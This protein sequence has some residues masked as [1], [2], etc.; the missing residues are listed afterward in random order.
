MIQ[1]Q[2]LKLVF[3][4]IFLACGSLA[5]FSAEA[6]QCVVNKGDFELHVYWYRPA[7]IVYRM[8]TT[9]EKEYQQSIPYSSKVFAGVLQEMRNVNPPVQIAVLKN[10]SQNCTAT[11]D[12]LVALFSVMHCA[13]TLIQN[14]IRAC[15]DRRMPVVIHGTPMEEGFGVRPINCTQEP[16]FLMSCLKSPDTSRYKPQFINPAPANWPLLVTAPPATNYLE[17]KG[18]IGLIEVVP[19]APIK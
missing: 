12:T 7:D 6:R 11:N 14:Y 8:D 5:S 13:D 2:I 16:D 1:K 18:Y 9:R 3:G 17:F 19:G 4:M 15:N 10:G